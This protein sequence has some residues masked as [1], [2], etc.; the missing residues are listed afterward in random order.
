MSTN[1]EDTLAVLK[2][3]KFVMEAPYHPGYED[4]VVD[5]GRP[6]SQVIRE[7]MRVSGKRFWAGDNISEF[8]N[9]VNCKEMLIDACDSLATTTMIRYW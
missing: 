1:K 5:Q 6:L 4:A 2:A 9:G 3:D 7:N 8:V